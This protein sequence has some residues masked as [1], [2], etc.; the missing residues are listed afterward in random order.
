[1]KFLLPTG[2]GDSVWAIHK[3]QAI[4]DKLDPGGS[5]N[6]SLVGAKSGIDSRALDFVRRFSFI[7]SVD[8]KSYSIQA[9]GPLVHPDGTYNYIEDGDYTFDGEHYIALVPNRTLEQGIRLEDWLPHH[10]IN[11]NIFESFRI[12][13]GERIYAAAI[14]E[15]LG[16]Y[17]VFYPGPLAGNTVEGHNR[18][19]IW[20]PQEWVELG[21]RVHE[22]FG[23]HILYVGAT[24]DRSYF[25]TMLKPL[26]TQ[27]SWPVKG[28]TCWWTSIIGQTNLGQL[29]ALTDRA[30]FV[31]SYQAGVG[32]ISTYLGTPTAIF[33]RQNGNSISQYAYLSFDERM[34]SA[35]VSPAVL[36]AGTH[37]PLYYGRDS[38]ESILN[39]VCRRGWHETSAHRVVPARM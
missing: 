7:N 27:E 35:W 8:M 1:M 15:K 24:Y 30:K 26:L 13:I 28:T 36:K 6:V 33:W 38:V 19:P 12:D 25:D 34:A 3:V 16:D 21:K 20:T 9:Y 31:I 22:E 17:A 39:E 23:L 18:G 4:R 32:I 10:A 14:H 5:I 37:L 2:I 29:W 11:W